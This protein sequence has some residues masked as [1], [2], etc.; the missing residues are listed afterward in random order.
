MRSR[1]RSMQASHPKLLN[2][3]R[4]RAATRVDQWREREI[5]GEREREISG[6]RERESS[7]EREREISG[8]LA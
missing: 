6:E 1:V 8:G 2:S 7:V 3:R 5:S 4:P